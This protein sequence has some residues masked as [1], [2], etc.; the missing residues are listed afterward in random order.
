MG[1]QGVLCDP[2]YPIGQAWIIG[3]GHQFRTLQRVTA[4]GVQAGYSPTVLRF[5]VPVRLINGPT[6]LLSPWQVSHGP[7]EVRLCHGEGSCVRFRTLGLLG[8]LMCNRRSSC[9]TCSQLQALAPIGFVT[10]KRRLVLKRGPHGTEHKR[11][12]TTASRTSL[13][14]REAMN[15]VHGAGLWRPGVRFAFFQSS[16]KFKTMPLEQL[17]VFTPVRRSSALKLHAPS[18]NMWEDRCPYPMLHQTPRRT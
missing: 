11:R 15:C 10:L 17:V 13:V 16:G 18:E 9:R 12:S 3:A 1:H 5:H 8:Q 6:V 14:T 4:A 2:A 7:T